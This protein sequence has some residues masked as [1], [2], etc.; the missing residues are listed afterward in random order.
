MKI[1]ESI[2]KGYVKKIPKQTERAKSLLKSSQQA[3]A[4]AKE[5]QLK[6]STLKT[7]FRELYEGF[8]EY[9]E[10]IGYFKGYKFLSHETITYFLDEILEEK[11]ISLK[12]DRYRKLR[13]KINYYG[14][15]IS[16]ETVKEALFGIP[17]LIDSL[18]KYL[19]SLN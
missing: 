7:I 3:I 1:N 4:T 6:E 18:K 17:K 8:R 13:N 15:N 16:Q 9:C 10:A 11:E 19:N 14:E 12:F 2:R 5:I